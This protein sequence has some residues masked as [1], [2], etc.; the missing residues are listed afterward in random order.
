MITLQAAKAIQTLDGIELGGR[1]I[2]VREDREDRDLKEAYAADGTEPPARPPRRPKAESDPAAAGAGAAAAPRGESSG[3]QIVVHGLPYSYT[4]RELKD[5]F[6]GMG[7][8]ERADVVYGRDGRSRGYGTVKFATQ[9]EA[10]AAIEAVNG[11]DV[12]G[13]EIKVNIDKFA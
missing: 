3:C 4:W 1:N 13:R 6:E 9:E 10:Q 8:I 11:K 5:M 12:D 7:T 2:N